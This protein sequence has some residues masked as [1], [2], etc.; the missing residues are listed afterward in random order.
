MIEERRG[1]LVLDELIAA[2][3]NSLIDISGN[4]VDIAIFAEGHVCGD[5]GAGTFWGFDDNGGSCQ[6]GDNPVALGEVKLVSGH[7]GRVF[8]EKNS[9]TCEHIAHEFSFGELKMIEAVP[10][11]GDRGEMFF[12]GFFVRDTVD[13]VGESADDREAVGDKGGDE[14]FRVKFSV[15]CALSRTDDGDGGGVQ[16][17]SAE[18]VQTFWR[19]VD[20]AQEC[21]ILGVVDCYEAAAFL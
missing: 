11:N 10:E 2:F 19:V 16:S 7:V 15:V 4:G 9:A 12:D 1:F 14:F 3:G 18:D 21:G 13:A 5:E 8:G 20:F 6:A 17:T